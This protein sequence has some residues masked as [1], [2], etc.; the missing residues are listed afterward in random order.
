MT[1]KPDVNLWT[2]ADH[3][4]EYLERADSIPHRTEGEAALLEFIP[5]E[6]RRILDLGTGSGRL[7]GLVMAEL[8]AREN[9]RN[10]KVEAVAVDFSPPCSKRLANASR[11]I[12][13]ST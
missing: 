11:K 8:A 6:T 12:R 10:S 9:G 1:T 3:A 5:A 7:L 13:R 4:H 2:S